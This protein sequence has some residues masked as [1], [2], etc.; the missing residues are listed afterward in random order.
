MA[1]GSSAEINLEQRLA[2][3][4][5]QNDGKPPEMSAPTPA[6]LFYGLDLRSFRNPASSVLEIRLNLSSDGKVERYTLEDNKVIASPQGK[7]TL[8]VTSVIMGQKME[9]PTQPTT[10]PLLVPDLKIHPEL[11]E[12]SLYHASTPAPSDLKP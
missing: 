2:Q 4:A 8:F 11:S 7:L 6:E 9:V 10:H 3:Y 1:T 12:L 5:K